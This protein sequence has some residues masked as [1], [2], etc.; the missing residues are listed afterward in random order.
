MYTSLE[1]LVERLNYALNNLDGDAVSL[2]DVIIVID[3]ERVFLQEG[4]SIAALNRM[5]LELEARQSIPVWQSLQ[6]LFMERLPSSNL[7][8]HIQ[9]DGHHVATTFVHECCDWIRGHMPYLPDGRLRLFHDTLAGLVPIVNHTA[10]IPPGPTA[11]DGER[12]DESGPEPGQYEPEPFDGQ[13]KGVPH[14]ESPVPSEFPPFIER[15][16]ILPRP[17]WND[18]PMH[19]RLSERVRKTFRTFQQPRGRGLEQLHLGSFFSTFFL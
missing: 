12:F 8:I 3:M 18:L 17:T 1:V 4:M 9:L 6:A 10:D 5:K 13:S 14:P 7:H 19:L 11:S 15:E 2:R 16:E